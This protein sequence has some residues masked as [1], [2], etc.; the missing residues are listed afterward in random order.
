MIALIGFILRCIAGGVIGYFVGVG[1]SAW[2]RSRS[3][4]FVDMTV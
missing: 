1:L 2:A 4:T 3:V